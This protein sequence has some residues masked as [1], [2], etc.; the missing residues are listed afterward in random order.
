MFLNFVLRVDK[1]EEG[2]AGRKETFSNVITGKALLFK[3]GNI[4]SL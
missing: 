1:L 4:E 2:A 3:N